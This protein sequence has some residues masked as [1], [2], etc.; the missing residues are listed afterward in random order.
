MRKCGIL[1]HPISLESKYGIGDLGD[2][3][4][5]FVDFLKMS[6]QRLWQV[7]PLGHTSFGDS[8]YQSFST[9]AGNPLLISIDILY[10]KEYLTKDDIS[11]V[12]EFDSQRIEYKRV[13]DFKYS[14]YRKA[15]ANFSKT[16]N[17][18]YINFCK[19]NA[20][21]LEDY[22]LYIAVKNYLINKRRNEINSIEYKNYYKVASRFMNDNKVK[23]CYYGASWNSFPSDIRDRNDEAINRYTQLLAQ[24]IEFYKFLQF[25]FYKQWLDLKKYANKNDIKIIGDIPI[26]VAADSVDTWVNKNLFRLDQNGFPLEVAGV[27]PD[28][29]SKFG[30]LWGNPLYNWENHKEGNYHWWIN[31]IKKTLETVDILRVDH[32]RGFDSYWSTK[33]GEET[34]IKGK[35]MKGPGKSIFNEIKKQLPSAKIIAEDLGELN[36]SVIMLRDAYNLPGMKILQFAF[37]NKDNSYLPHNYENNNFVVY[38]GTH[39]N[40]TIIGWYNSCN[41]Q[42]KDYIRRV[43]NVSGEEINWDII[44]YAISSSAKYSIIPIQDIL[45]LDSEGRMNTPGKAMGNWQFRFANNQLNTA[46][47]ERLKYLCELFNR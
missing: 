41:E 26:F 13:I 1:M 33:F 19:K 25:E 42:I 10:K 37:G 9:F 3:A 17:K 12:P 43:L 47:S 40:D 29:F 23:D 45:G 39:D 44:R 6:G 2:N 8:P 11:C 7:L 20:F 27:P 16:I 32:F 35:W 24:E 22:S 30:Q 28:Y 46:I 36:E 21:W 15:F 5:L 38:T 4:K 18:E 34:S 14:I 31:R